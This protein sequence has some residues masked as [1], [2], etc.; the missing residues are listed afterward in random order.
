MLRYKTETRPDLVALYDIRPE[1]RAGQFLQPR[2]PHGVS[3]GAVSTGEIWA[4]NL[5]S[6]WSQTQWYIRTGG[7]RQ[8]DEH[9]LYARDGRGSIYSNPAQPKMS[10]TPTQPKLPL[11]P[12]VRV[13]F[14]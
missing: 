10:S 9:C 6:H 14:Q 2:S 4:G 13:T 3:I 11:Q 5:A 7:F 12:N 1:N 8:G